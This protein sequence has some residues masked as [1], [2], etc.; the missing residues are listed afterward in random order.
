MRLSDI[1]GER[2]F[3]VM[4]DLIEPVASLATDENVSKFFSKAT[5]E[6]GQSMRDYAIA[7]IRECVPSLLRDHK[8]ELCAI[9]SSIEGVTVDEY[10]S[11][12]TMASLVND[13]IEL[14]NDSEFLA[15][16]A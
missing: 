3:D 9:L 16:F 5:P 8:E 14:L 15:F 13:V 7:R 6:E 12:L 4:A 11:K 2:V 10:V 1:K